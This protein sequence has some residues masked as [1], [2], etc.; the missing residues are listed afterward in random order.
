[1]PRRTAPY[2]HDE[3]HIFVSKAVRLLGDRYARWGVTREDLQ[4]EL[5]VWLLSHDDKVQR[6]LASEPQQTT[7]IFRSLY[8]CGRKYAEK[9]KAASL[10]YEADDVQWYTASL[11]ESVLPWA[12]DLDWNGMTSNSPDPERAGI[13]KFVD[14][15]VLTL[16]MDVRK[17]ID[18]TFTAFTLLNESPGD[19]G[20]EVAIQMVVDFLGGNR[21]YVGRR[22]VISNGRAQNITDWEDEVA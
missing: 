1:M 15:D 2:V 17:G 21:D 20:Y 6:W 18:K 7:R 11:V 12:L 5:I 13:A 3:L 8:D 4:Q 19:D 10:G 22:K 16:V 14:D 9:E